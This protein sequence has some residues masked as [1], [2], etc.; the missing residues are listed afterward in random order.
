MTKQSNNES[1]SKVLCD[2]AP[3]IVFFIAFKTSD[4]PNPLFFAT[5]CLMVTTFIALIVSYVLTRK[6]SIMALASGLLLGTFG[7]LTLIFKDEIFIKLKPTIVNLLFAS[8]LFYGSMAKKPLI[9]YLFGS[10][11]TMSEQSWIILSWRWA[12]FFLFLALLNEVIWRNFSTDF[13]VQ[14]KLFGMMPISIIF[15]ITQT[16]FIMRNME[17]S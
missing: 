16:P 5:I 4:N 17:K 3:I 13:W 12:Y 8:I 2:Y 15:A 9:S 14:F 11:L 10:Q 1:L 7:G 6:I